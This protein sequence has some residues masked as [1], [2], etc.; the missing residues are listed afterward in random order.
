MQFGLEKCAKASFK[1]GKLVKTSNIIID[2]KTVIKELEQEKSYKYLGVNEGDGIQHAKMKEQMKK[3]CIRRVRLITKTEL[4]AK[5]RILAVNTL[6]LPVMKFSYNIINWNLN[7]LNK[8]DIKI[9]KLLTCQR[10]HHPKADVASFYIPRNKGGRGLMQLELC[11]KTTT[12]RLYNYLT[13]TKDSML[14]LTL[15]HAS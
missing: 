1:R 6:E 15:H 7:E 14:K 8:I 5:N 13:K 12:I 10:M 9:R 2:N 11:Y 3:E 4:N